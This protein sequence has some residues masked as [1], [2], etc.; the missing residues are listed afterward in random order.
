M[1]HAYVD[2]DDVLNNFTSDLGQRFG[3][4]TGGG[5]LSWFPPLVGYD[6]LGALHHFGASVGKTHA[7]FW[8]TLPAYCW[9]GVTKSD[10]CDKLIKRLL[11]DYGPQNITI[12]TAVAP[13]QTPSS[14]AGKVEWIEKNL[15]KELHSRYIIIA[16]G[17]K[18]RLA[19]CDS[20]LID[21][22]PNNCA[23]FEDHCGKAILVN[24]PWNRLCKRRYTRVGKQLCLIPRYSG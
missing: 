16:T 18:W 11:A 13:G 14:V 24:R 10:I 5:D 17:E 3:L 7:E 15:P 1:Y 9:S 6:M 21:D 4:G 8:A 2:L 12:C 22:N 19:D 20:V 23:M